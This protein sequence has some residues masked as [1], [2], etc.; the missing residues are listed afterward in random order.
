MNKQSCGEQCF[1][2]IA[3][4]R[5]ADLRAAETSG[6]TDLGPDVFESEISSTLADT[7]ST[8]LAVVC[9]ERG[10]NLIDVHVL[11][12]R[13]EALLT[14]TEPDGET[15]E[16]VAMALDGA[17]YGGQGMSAAGAMN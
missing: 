14:G 16:G 12:D 8:R 2:H 15:G 5:L 13:V 11:P 4:Y 7:L 17:V 3:T 1:M 10:W 6:S 9:D